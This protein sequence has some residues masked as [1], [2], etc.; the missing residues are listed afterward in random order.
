[1]NFSEAPSLDQSQID[2]WQ[3]KEIKNCN[4]KRE[5][6]NDLTSN[7]K[8]TEEKKNW[9]QRLDFTW[10]WKSRFLFLY[11]S[12]SFIRETGELRNIFFYLAE[13]PPFLQNAITEKRKKGKYWV[14]CALRFIV[15]VRDTD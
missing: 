9:S 2:D 5:N 11:F 14:I 4:R 13:F 12:L 1:M 15:L 10:N 6:L 7:E 8:Q 3:T